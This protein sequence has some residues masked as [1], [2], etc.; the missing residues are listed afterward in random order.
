M[1]EILDLEGSQSLQSL[2]SDVPEPVIIL[3]EPSLLQKSLEFLFF[4]V[5][6]RDERALYVPEQVVLHSFE[7]AKQKLVSSMGLGLHI[8]GY[9][10]VI[11]QGGRSLQYI[12]I[13]TIGGDGK[14]LEPHTPTGQGLRVT[15]LLLAG[16][17][18]H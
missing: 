12:P 2:D 18:V 14:L 9:H 5:G 7:V 3:L 1:I 6:L 10:G 17:E 4:L 8:S 11:V 16:A 15:G 13:E